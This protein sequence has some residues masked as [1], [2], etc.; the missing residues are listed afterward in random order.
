MKNMARYGFILALICMV[1]SGLLA[2]VNSLTK[3]RI[4]AQAQAEEEASLK[5]IIP[6]AVHFE[7]V[8]SDN[9]IIYYKAHNKEGKLVAVAFKAAGKGYASTVETMVGMAPDGEIIAIK[10]VAQNETPGL[11]AQVVEPAFTTQFKRKNIQ[12]LNQVQA[13]TGASISSKAIIEAVKKKAEEIKELIKN[14]PKNE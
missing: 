3:S 13:I 9:E 1:A 12:N 5:E 8:K 6:E 10:V 4:I 11:G 7:P 14:V 2:G